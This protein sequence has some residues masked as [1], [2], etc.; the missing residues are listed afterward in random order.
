MHA[1]EWIW[2]EMHRLCATFDW[3]ELRK[4]VCVRERKREI[5]SEREREKICF[6]F[7]EFLTE[8]HTHSA[9]H[10]KY[11]GKFEKSRDA[12]TQTNCSYQTKCFQN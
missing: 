8:A 10:R 1:Y 6:G 7:L 4:C 3:T 9:L 11:E 2:N 5:E 12:Q